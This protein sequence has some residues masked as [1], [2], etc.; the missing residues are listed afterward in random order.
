MVTNTFKM[1]KKKKEPIN[2]IFEEC[3]ASV[4]DINSI[5]SQI[6]KQAQ[7]IRKAKIE[8]GRLETH[9]HDRCKRFYKELTNTI[10]ARDLSLDD[11]ELRFLT[12]NLSIGAEKGKVRLLEEL[13]RRSQHDTYP[14]IDAFRTIDLSKVYEIIG[15]ETD[16]TIFFKR[17]N[18]K[19]ETIIKI[20]PSEAYRRIGNGRQGNRR[21]DERIR[22]KLEFIFQNP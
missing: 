13:I 10:L 3:S 9:R 2:S 12:M 15:I 18:R 17:L 4:K 21:D 6:S 22:V 20:T 8:I 7:V 11:A 19:L 5:N 16:L 1:R 14:N